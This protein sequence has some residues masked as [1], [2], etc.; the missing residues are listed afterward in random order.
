MPTFSLTKLSI[1]EPPFRKLKKIEFEFAPR[2]T[3]IAGHN[4]IGKSTIL[5]LVANGSGLTDSDHS[6]YTGKTFQ[7]NLNEIIHLDY[8]S[9]FAEKKLANTLPR[10]V[11]EYSLDGENFKKRCAL[12][13][14]TVPATESKAERLEARVVP[15]NIP[16]KDYE[17]P[18]TSIVIGS[19]SKVP[20]PTIY[21]GM[22]RMLPIGES[23]PEMVENSPDTAIHPLDIDFITTFVNGVIGVSAK[24]SAT[25]SITTQSIKGTNKTT[26]HPAYSHSPKTVSLGQDSLS[27]IATALA[28]F[29]KL[30]REWDDYPGGLLVIDELDAGF[31]PHAQQKLIKSIGNTAKKLNIQVVATTH[32][33]CLIEAI[34]PDANPIGVKGTY[35]D[36]VIYVR[37]TNHPKIKDSSLQSIKDDMNLT[38]PK[39]LPKPETKYLKVYLEDAEANRFIKALITRRVQNRVKEA[40]GALLKPIPISV[41]C[42]NLQGL[43]QFDP[44]FKTVLIAVDADSKVRTGS[45][46]KKIKNVVKLPG[47]SDAAGRGFNPER[48][49]YEFVKE[50]IETEENYTASR[51]YL[52]S[53]GVTSDQLYNHLID[54]DVNITK[55]ESSKSWMKARLEII[56]DWNLIGLWLAENPEKVKAFEEELLAAAVATAKLTF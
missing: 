42:E 27:A 1:S 20:I 36:K 19:S 44:H 33:L 12:T 25:K 7:G 45:G 55:R 50:L 54:G 2:I 22:T 46:R 41:G 6:S 17:L 24:N 9:E 39:P 18:G 53:L 8:D 30:K 35:V 15:R 48:T 11:L 26:K 5:A 32:S 47:G 13:K 52:E 51:E 23:D 10:P 14:R 3:L 4:G 21:L 43:Q 29:Q 40:C 37:D 56:D 34:H 28:S 16:L 38:P 31:H 49:I